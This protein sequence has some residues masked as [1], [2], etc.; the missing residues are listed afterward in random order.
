ME[1]GLKL[2]ANNEHCQN[3]KLKIWQRRAEAAQQADDMPTVVEASIHAAEVPTSDFHEISEVANL[4]NQHGRDFEP[5]QGRRQVLALRLAKVMESRI[6]SA[7][8]ND[9]SRLAWVLL[10]AGESKRAKAIVDQG[11][12]IDPQNDHCLKLKGRLEVSNSSS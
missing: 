2:D 9:C 7:S 1:S 12:R 4:F 3:L 11:L 10:N 8:A 5:D 6:G